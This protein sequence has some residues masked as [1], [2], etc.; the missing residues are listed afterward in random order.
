MKNIAILGSTGSIGMNALDVISRFPARFRV[1]CLSANT[2]IETLSRQVKKFK[3]VAVCVADKEK[4]RQFRAGKK[5]GKLKIYEGEQGLLEMIEANTMDTLLVAIVGASALM[6]I[7]TSLKKI[8]KLAL[9]NKEA[10]VMAGNI[11]MKQ[12]RAKKVKVLPVDSEH[13]AVF[14]CISPDDGSAV[15]KI[16]LTGSGGPL[17]KMHKTDFSKVSARKAVKHPKWDMGKKISVDSSTMMNKGLEVIEAHRLFNLPVDRIEVVIHPETVIHSM[18]EFMDNS[19]LA[20]MGS[21]DM[22]IPIQ[23]ALTY[24]ERS[25]SPARSLNFSEFSKLHFYSPDFEKFPALRLAYEAGKKDG[26]CPCVLNA[27]NEVAVQE[28]IGENIL[29][30]DIVDTVEKVL[31]RHKNIKS[32]SLRDITEADG[33]ARRKAK[34]ILG[35]NDD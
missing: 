23:Y 27:A 12:A 15:K 21:C 4:A 28:F 6:P 7:L 8:K 31:K 35:V 13:S 10:L 19:I 26:T 32:P 11:I 2:N 34:E 9:A 29:F 22:R 33:W 14:Q 24:P 18:V 20:Q 30:T 3:P 17:L 16:Y 1:T 25:K 5:T